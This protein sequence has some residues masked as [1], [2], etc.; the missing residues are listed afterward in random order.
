[1]ERENGFLNGR[2]F[3]LFVKVLMEKGTEEEFL[4]ED[5]DKN[6]LE[7]KRGSEKMMSLKLKAE[8]VMLNVLSGNDPVILPT[9]GKGKEDAT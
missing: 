7:V 1:M 9:Q 2:S 6:V 5:F 8:G 4:K 3:K